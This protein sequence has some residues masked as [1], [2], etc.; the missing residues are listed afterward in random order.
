MGIQ[1][2]VNPEVTIYALIVRNGCHIGRF[3]LSSGSKVRLLKSK[4]DD[5]ADTFQINDSA[6]IGTG[7]QYPQ[8]LLGMTSVANEKDDKMGFP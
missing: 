4:Q 6:P 1:A 5:A 7:G 3:L 8:G 2:L